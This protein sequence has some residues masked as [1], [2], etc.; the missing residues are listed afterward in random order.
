MKAQL[1]HI[2][3]LAFIAIGS[4]D[5]IAIDRWQTKGTVR[6]SESGEPL[7]DTWILA[8]FSGE[9]PLINLPIPPHP[10]HRRS[11][12]MGTQAV[13]TDENGQFRFNHLTYNRSLANKW[14]RIVVFKPG[15]IAASADAPMRSSLFART[16]IGPNLSLTLGSGQ[17]RSATAW[18]P[19]VRARLPS[20]EF[21]YS[22]ELFATLRV[23][24]QAR[25]IC[26]SA[27]DDVLIAAMDH[28]ISIAK[29]FDERF[30]TRGRCHRAA[31]ILGRRD[32]AWPFDC[33]NL[34]FKHQPSALVLAVETDLR[35]QRKTRQ[36]AD[37]TGGTP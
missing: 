12:C 17:S 25:F 8:T 30:R 34:G 19:N 14:A 27:G 33:D 29:S 5:W 20:I 26:G 9:A 4:V 21:S 28:A 22:E 35:A 2:I 11:E 15:W 3:A 13:R 16:P 32:S 18:P 31:V 37:V 36:K 24:A 7:P 23:V 1:K 6:D 10:N